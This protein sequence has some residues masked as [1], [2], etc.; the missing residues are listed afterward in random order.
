MHEINTRHQ[1]GITRRHSHKVAPETN[2]ANIL[3]PE[4]SIWKPNHPPLKQIL[5]NNCLGDKFTATV[6][7]FR[8]ILVANLSD[9]KISGN[10]CSL[11]TNI[12]QQL[13]PWHKYQA[14]TSPLRQTLH[15]SGI[16]KRDE[17]LDRKRLFTF[18]SLWWRR[19][20]DYNIL[21]LF[22]KPQTPFNFPALAAH[23]KNIAAFSKW[24]LLMI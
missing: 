9:K 23:E 15:R 19:R 11:G 2:I 12:R 18:S 4:I 22:T 21:L 1:H 24:A 7:L 3:S 17:I 20:E 13:F 6:Y 16:H 8:Q 10:T 14:T 5:G